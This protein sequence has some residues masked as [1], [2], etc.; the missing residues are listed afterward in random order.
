M[1]TPEI[2]SRISSNKHFAQMLR[3]RLESRHGRST[4]IRVALSRLDDAQLI[5][6]YLRHERTLIEQVAK[7][8]AE[9]GEQ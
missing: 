9:R 8:Q 2:E 1:T 3:Q 5:E 7:L 4:Y 6:L